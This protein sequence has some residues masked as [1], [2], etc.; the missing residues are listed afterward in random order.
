MR[1]SLGKLKWVGIF[2]VICGLATVGICD[3][4]YR[5]NS[6]GNNTTDGES[7]W[8]PFQHLTIIKE[9]SFS[10]YDATAIFH[11]EYFG[12]SIRGLNVDVD[13]SDNKTSTSI[14]IGDLLIVC[15]QVVVASQMV[16]EEKFIAKYDVPALQGTQNRSIEQ[17]RHC[18]LTV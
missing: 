7:E 6:G 10:A 17:A 16:Y 15:A 13:P 8:N 1:R 9:S 2:F 12:G 4:I 11:N 5:N 18:P 3:M 14:L